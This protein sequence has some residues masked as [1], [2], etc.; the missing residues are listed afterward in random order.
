MNKTAHTLQ[1]LGATLTY[2][3]WT[4]R[5]EHGDYATD[6]ALRL[7]ELLKAQHGRTLES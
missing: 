2:H 1:V 4:P 3:I 6:I 5:P 7:A